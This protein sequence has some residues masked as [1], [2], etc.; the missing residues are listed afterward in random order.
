[1]ARRQQDL[2]EAYFQNADTYVSLA[3]EIYK[4]PVDQVTEGQ[5]QVGKIARLGLGYQMG[6]SKF[7][8]T[9]A[10]YDIVLE[11]KFCQEVVTT[12]RDAST[13][14]KRF[15]YDLERAAIAC[16]ESGKA[17]RVGKITFYRDK[18]WF[19][20]PF[21]IGRNIPYFLPTVDTKR[22][23]WGEKKQLSY[24]TI[25][26]QTKQFR[27]ESTYGGKWAENIVQGTCRDL[28]VDAMLRLE[29]AKRPVVMH[30]HDEVVVEVPEGVA[31]VQEIEAIVSRP[32]KWATG[33]PVG[34]EGFSSTRY[35]K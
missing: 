12:Y 7:Q 35:R 15:W 21:A 10:Q 28:L 2:I 30:V 14:I 32:P 23:E 20:G 24:M 4:V 29:N 6:W 8:A 34:V 26:S 33:C 11:D 17:R 3:A 16:V 25:S 31:T 1:M 18:R 27:R 9:A 19:D 5:R 13:Q 22:S